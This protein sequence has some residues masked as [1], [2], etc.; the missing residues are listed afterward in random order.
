M[1]HIAG[2]CFKLPLLKLVTICLGGDDGSMAIATTQI[3]LKT[4]TI[5]SSPTQTN[6]NPHFPFEN[7]TLITA[8]PTFKPPHKPKDGTSLSLDTKKAWQ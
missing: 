5:P 7:I 8:Y 2:W 1:C 6:H 4:T 3:K